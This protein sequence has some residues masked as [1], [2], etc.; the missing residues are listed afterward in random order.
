MPDPFTLYR[1]VEDDWEKLRELRIRM[2][3]DTPIAYLERLED[4]EKLTEADWRARVAR[5]RT[6]RNRQVVAV[7]GDGTWIASMAVFIT[8]GLPSYLGKPEGGAPRA[9]LVGVFVAPD[10]R[11]ATGVN[12]AV[13]GEL[14]AWVV[15]D[16]DIHQ[17]HLHVSMENPRARR[18]YEKRG[19]VDTGV[20]E[21]I[22]GDLSSEEMEMV[23]AL[24]LTPPRTQ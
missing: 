22:P 6:E 1:P 5:T 3:T 17:L 10:W 15:G 11:G 4:V 24:P 16:H 9:N 2:I 21:T 18:S 14:A 13:L 12:D 20:R 7:D 23:A 19:F 8:D